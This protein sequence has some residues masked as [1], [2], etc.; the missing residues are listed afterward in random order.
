M[1]GSG[2][3]LPSSRMPPALPPLLQGATGLIVGLILLN[4]IRHPDRS[5][6]ST[7][8]IGLGFGFGGFIGLMVGASYL[9]V[10]L[11]VPQPDSILFCLFFFFASLQSLLSVRWISSPP[12]R[13]WR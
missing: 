11:H 2:L 1:V 3:H 12:K 6:L 4:S 5:P 13:L 8:A 7:V 10:V 9:T